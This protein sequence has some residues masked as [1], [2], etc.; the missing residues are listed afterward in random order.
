MSDEI[1]EQL[2]D[3]LR[4]AHAI[5][6]QAL[7]QLREAPK[8]AGDDALAA[9]FRDHL[10]ETESHERLVRELLETR[11]EGPSRFKDAV[12]AVGGKG[13][14]WFARAQTD[15]PGKLAAHALS[16][17]ALELAS[18]E[19]L[20][21][22]ADRAGERDVVETARRIAADERAMLERLEGLFDEAVNASLEDTER[23]DLTDKLRSFLADAHALEQ[24]GEVLLKR[25]REHAGD[26]ELEHAYADHL[27]E[28]REHARLVEERLEALGGKPS[29]LKDS[30]LR[31]GGVNW[32]AFFQA[33]PDT[34][35]K[36][37]VFAFAF[38]H[39]EIGGY[40]QLKRVAQ[41]AGDHETVELAH[42]ILE[43]ERAAA[44]RLASA[45]DEAAA[46][47]LQAQAG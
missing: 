43:Q 35:G 12:M 40:E 22:V 34:P 11:G 31:L 1:H 44:G 25:A 24:Q 26:P 39:L 2:L 37:A 23:P 15:T 18:Y 13:F 28:T 46:A 9:A 6:E 36:L 33:H 3:Y 10:A 4:D 5:E 17:E 8:I 16:Y 27:E 14:V 47:A 30:A 19:L 21:R 42:R 20:A 41:R 45:F 29:L 32:S 38:E 7:A